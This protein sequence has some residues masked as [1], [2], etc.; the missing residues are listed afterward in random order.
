MNWE[1]FKAEFVARFWL[2]CKTTVVGLILALADFLLHY[3]D[4]IQGTPA[5]VHAVI[6]AAS[7]ILVS[8][9]GKLAATGGVAIKLLV[10]GALL[11]Q[12]SCTAFKVYTADAGACAAQA[13]QSLN[14]QDFGPVIDNMLHNEW[15][16]AAAKLG[17]LALTYGEAWVTCEVGKAADRLAAKLTPA[18]APEGAVTAR[19]LVSSDVGDHAQAYDNA[20]RWLA[21]E[22]LR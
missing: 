18:P 1:S 21:G 17:D 22:R 14:G 2:A 8:Y 19:A 10:L 4:A 11:S 9:R 3:F 16:F 7:L 15:A 13:T 20:R 12:P 6:G 5:W